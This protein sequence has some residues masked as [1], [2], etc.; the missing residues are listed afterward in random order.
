MKTTALVISALVDALARHDPHSLSELQQQY[1][2]HAEILRPGKRLG[3][4]S[5]DSQ[6]LVDLG[7]KAIEVAK[8]QAL[9]AQDFLNR[10]IRRTMQI[11]L[12][13]NIFSAVSAAGVFGAVLTSQR[14]VSIAT[15]IVGF[16]CSTIGLVAQYLEGFSG[17]NGNSLRGLREQLGQIAFEIAETEG[18][19]R[20]L[21]AQNSFDNNLVSLVQRANTLVARLRQAEVLAGLDID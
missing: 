17:G 1:P 21:I 12:A 8:T 4:V 2:Q 16:C 19:F 18:E 13:S 14:A 9:R 15:A 7:S 11:R 3:N 10:R 5:Y 20:L 6:M